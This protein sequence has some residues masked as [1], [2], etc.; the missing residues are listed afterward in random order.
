VP[1]QL[2]DL[3][4]SSPVEPVRSVAVVKVEVDCHHSDVDQQ[5]ERCGLPV[6]LCR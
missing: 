3:A 2:R 1:V 4:C 5:H 6:Q